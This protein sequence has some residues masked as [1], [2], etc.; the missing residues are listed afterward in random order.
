MSDFETAVVYQIYPRSFKDSNSDGIGDLNGITEKLDYLNDGSDNSLGINVIWISPVY[1]SPM[2]DFGYDVTDHTDVDPIFGTLKDFDRLIK[3]A[4]KRKIKVIMDF[5]PNHTSHLHPWFL[6][7]SSSRDNPKR[8]WY[9]WRDPKPD[10]SPPNNWVSIFG[11]SRWEYDTKTNQYFMHTFI[12]K[13]PDL[14]WRN[15]QVNEAMLNILRFWLQRGVDGF[16]VDGFE[17]IFKHTDFLDEPS[18][19]DYKHGIDD[20]YK[21]HKHIHTRNQD[22]L[23]SLV[24]IFNEVLAEFGEKF[25]ITE[26]YSDL[27]T[28]LKLYQAGNKL[29][30]P[31]NFHFIL[32]P[33]NAQI[34]KEFIDEFDEQVGVDYLPNYVLSNHDRSRVAS[35]I[36]MNAARTA[37]MLQLTLRGMPTIYYGEEIGMKDVPIPKELVQDPFEKNVPG[38]GLGRD[39]SRT[40]LQWNSEKHAGFSSVNPWLPTAENYRSVNI[41]EES[42]DP[43]SFLNLYKQLIHFRKRSETLLFGTYTSLVIKKK[44]VFAYIREYKKEKILIVLNFSGKQKMVE[45]PFVQG[46]IILNTGLDQQKGSVKKLQ[47][48]SLRPHEG[49]MFTILK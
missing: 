6:E 41:A 26:S 16:R 44:D 10:G 4:H 39:P 29:H 45:L 30:A 7:S 31:F 20:P 36:G 21:I 40:P 18:N 37:V 43:R 38:M 17:H 27:P 24:A 12:T 8:D 5:I 49:Y 19:P 42:Q 46:K 32:L 15:P 23:Y 33:W 48:I 47:K 22:E 35:R 28:L 1:K 3:E 11:G 13:Q 9:V 2:Y 14:N 25:M 34:Y